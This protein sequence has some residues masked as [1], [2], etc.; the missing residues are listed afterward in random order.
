MRVCAWEILKHMCVLHFF[1]NEFKKGLV[2]LTDLCYNHFLVFYSSNDMSTAIGHRLIGLIFG[3][4]QCCCYNYEENA[5]INDKTDQFSRCVTG[6]ISW[7][8]PGDGPVV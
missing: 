7:G 6:A 1:S 2:K 8:R 4:H 3:K 5:L